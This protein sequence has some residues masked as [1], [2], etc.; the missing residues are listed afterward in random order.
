M[1]QIRFTNV[2]CRY[3]DHVLLEDANFVVNR[4]DRIAIIGRN[5]A[6]KSTLLKLI[7]QSTDPDSGD[8]KIQQSLRIAEMPQHVPS[9]LQGSLRDYLSQT[10]SDDEAYL[11]DKIIS[12]LQLDPDLKLENASGGQVRRVLLGKALLHE[13]DVLILDE[14]TNHLDIASIEWL[15]GFLRNYPNTIIFI[16]HDRTFMQAIATRIFEIDIGYL[17][18]WDGSYDGFLKHKAIQLAAEETAKKNFDKKL[19]QEERWIRQGIKARR[20]RNE[21]RVR[22]LKKMRDERAKRRTRTGSLQLQ[23]Q[24]QTS[25]SKLAFKI[26]DLHI[27]QGGQTLIERLNTV[28]RHQDKIGIIGPNGCG[29]ST[30]IKALLQALTPTSGC[31]ERGPQTK[32]AYFDQHRSKLDLNLTAAENVSGG[33]EEIEINGKRKHVI[34]YLQDFLFTGQ[35]ARSLVRSFSGGERNRLLLAKIIAEPSNVLILDEPTNDLDVETLEFLEEFL[36]DY[37]GALLVVSH[38]RS[39]LNNVVTSTLVFEG[40]GKVEEYV[41]G[42]DDWLR[43]RKAQGAKKS[44]AIVKEVA[45]PVATPSKKK[46]SYNEQRELNQLPE[47]IEKLEN[48]IAALQEKIVAPE[49]YQDKDASAKT[50]ARLSALEADLEAAYARWEALE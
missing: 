35:K 19:A 28:I 33:R 15:E 31:I 50:L 18:S 41:G 30:L 9:D 40:G 16:T 20:T 34:S 32:I 8:I 21:G 10:I 5:G 7:Q 27:E 45:K 3:G 23:Q 29:K 47:K 46:L 4:R 22:A 25:A 39:L 17:T 12:Q 26:S 2:N 1:S 43:Q 42:Y 24:E 44:E 48:E 37:P 36:L 49:F 38:D 6:G 13:P 14:P 11:V